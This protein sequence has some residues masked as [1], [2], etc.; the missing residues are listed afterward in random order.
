MTCRA[1]EA[2]CAAVNPNAGN[3]WLAGAD[4][5]YRSMAMM[6]P[7]EPTQRSQPIETPAS[8]LT[9]RAS[10]GGRTSSRYALGAAAKRSQLGSDTTRVRMPSRVSSARA[11]MASDSSEPVAMRMT[12]A[13]AGWPSSSIASART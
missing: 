13:A 5:P 1:T 6:A 9:R 2:T 7:S 10:V 12:S 11:S 4:A 8:M 3:S